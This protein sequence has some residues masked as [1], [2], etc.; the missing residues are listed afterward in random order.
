MILED[1]V[2]TPDSVMLD[3]NGIYIYCLAQFSLNNV[4]KRGLKHH[5]LFLSHK[6]V[7]Y[8]IAMN[9]YILGPP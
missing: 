6:N 2:C 7:C 5:H 8:I 9:D 4:H 1:S 3:N